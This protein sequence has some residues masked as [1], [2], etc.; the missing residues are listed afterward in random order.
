MIV[1]ILIYLLIGT[2]TAIADPCTKI[3]QKLTPTPPA[4]MFSI[5]GYA[6]YQQDITGQSQYTA[7]THAGIRIDVPLY[8]PRE[9]WEMK[10]EYLRAL[11]FARRILANYLK[12]RYEV[13]EMKK[14]LTWQWQRVQEGIEYRKDVWK[15]EIQLK[16]KQGQLKALEV[17]L[18]SSGI[19]KKEL[20]ECYE[21]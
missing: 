5:K 18:T 4:L 21:R 19:T 16:Q 3:V 15:E 7:P 14:Y 9:K 2:A 20:R 11:D 6:Q 10:K 12:L 13:E 17:L 1:G 8:D